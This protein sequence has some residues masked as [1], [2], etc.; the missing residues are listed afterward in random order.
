MRSLKESIL[1]TT[2]VGKFDEWSI[3]KRE[4][5]HPKNREELKNTIEQAIKLKGNKV[6]LNWIDVSGITDMSGVFHNSEFNGDI[7]KWD[8]HNVKDMSF[9]FAYSEFN[10]DISK[11]DVSNAEIIYGMFRKSKFSG[12]ISKWDVSNVKDM[13]Y[14]VWNSPL[15]KNPPKWYRGGKG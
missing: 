4:H 12:D 14:M 1:S 5:A 6:D 9:M 7:S 11:W 13:S 8:V 2:K 10:G 3:L 15:A